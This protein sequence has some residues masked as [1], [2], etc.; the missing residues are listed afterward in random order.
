MTTRGIRKLANAFIPDAKASSARPS[1]ARP[2]VDRFKRRHGGLWVRGTVVVSERGVSFL[3]NGLNLTL[4]DGLATIEVPA[5]DIQAV[6]YEFGWVTG[7][8]VV[9][10]AQ[11]ELR[12]RCFGAKRLA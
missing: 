1:F 5:Q 3:P 4:H 12:F 2:A 8:V 10:H 7:I 9:D 6:R 11:G